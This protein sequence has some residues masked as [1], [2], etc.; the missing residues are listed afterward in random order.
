MTDLQ[1][2]DRHI[3]RDGS[4]YTAAFMSLLPQGQAWPKG[5]GSVMELTCRGLNEYWGTVDERAAHL[6][7]QE[8]DPRITI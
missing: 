7:E 3:R 4:D 5:L 1:I 8:S 6:L 2:R